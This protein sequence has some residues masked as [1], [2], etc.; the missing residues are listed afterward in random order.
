MSAS[1]HLSTAFLENAYV[2]LNKK[3][4]GGELPPVIITIQSSPRAYG[5]YT[6]WENTWVGEGQGFH[7]INIGAETLDRDA[8]E[9]LATLSH[10]MC[11]H[12]CAVNNIKD[13]SRGGTY[14]NKK[15]KEVA[16]GT[17]AILVDYDPRIGYSPTRPTDA[18][19]AFIEEQGWTGV[20]LSRQSI[21][22]LPGGKGRGRSNG[23]RKYVCPNCHCSVRA[24][25]A[26]NIGCLDCGTVMELEEK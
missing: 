2:A 17:G 14:H 21:L 1:G 16:E 18:L 11:H 7:E 12:Y 19:I 22:G 15:F 6:T 23:V 20:N 5:H 4:F 26:V 8:S 10:E 24:T 13:T 9:V 25:K 3:F